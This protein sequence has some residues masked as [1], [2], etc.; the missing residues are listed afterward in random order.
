MLKIKLLMRITTLVKNYFAFVVLLVYFFGNNNS[1]YS[2]CPTVTNAAQSFCDS[3]SPTIASL[4]ATGLGGV[5][6]YSNPSGGT[7]LSSST[8]IIDGATYY[9]DDNAQ[10]CSFRPSVTVTIYSKPTA[11]LGSIQFCQA[12]TVADLAPYVIGN[13]IKWY[14]TSSAQTSLLWST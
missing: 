9:A 11:I 12:S 6:W 5:N 2:Q 7:S 1:L 3:Q 8:P 4:V 13:Q 14:L 10:T